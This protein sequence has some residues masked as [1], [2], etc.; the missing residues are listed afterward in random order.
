MA[1]IASLVSRPSAL[2]VGKPIM[3]DVAL[4]TVASPVLSAAANNGAANPGTSTAATGTDGAPADP[5]AALLA[6]LAPAREEATVATAPAATPPIMMPQPM[7]APK[8]GEA[9]AAP[10]P[11]PD[12]DLLA[13]AE[14]DGEETE[15]GDKD[16]TGA[17]PDTQLA[18]MLAIA[19]PKM[20]PIAVPPLASPAPQPAGPAA[21]GSVATPP[22]ATSR[23]GAAASP[24]ATQAGDST[25]SAQTTGA[26]L[27]A[28]SRA[29][30]FA[31]LLGGTAAGVSQPMDSAAAMVETDPVAAQP[32]PLPQAPLTPPVDPKAIVSGPQPSQHGDVRISARATAKANA[33]GVG[34]VSARTGIDLPDK[35]A[36]GL[37]AAPTAPH[38]ASAPSAD[39]GIAAPSAADGIAAKTLSMANDHQWLDTLARDIAATAGKDG[40]MSFRLDPQHLGSLTV[41]IRHTD[42]GAAIRLSA[43]TEAARA[44]LADAQ[45]RLA[46]E[47]KA[48]GLTLSSTSV[49]V[50]GSGTG[51][52]QQQGNASAFASL[53]QG[54][55]QRESGRGQTFINPNAGEGDEPARMANPSRDRSDLF[56]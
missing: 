14:K 34:A 48:Q 40:S 9:K 15:D 25:P 11:A 46:A 38:A 26:D 22:I 2:T 51:Q 5:F 31:R 12:P 37:S 30:V 18:M 44:I 35:N 39:V 1:D 19:E 17:D 55:S 10:S 52:S 53:A 7:P 41:H 33:A 28:T 6:S 49:D 3:A 50:G 21:A 27:N 36:G 56:A 4:G 43:N 32:Q 45:P 8:P 20:P 47:A 23:E 54:Q 29:A 13:L 24:P 16:D 42:D